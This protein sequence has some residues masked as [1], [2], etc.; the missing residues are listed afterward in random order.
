MG[1]VK[2]TVIGLL[3]VSTG[4]IYVSERV[5]NLKEIM[6]KLIPVPSNFRNLS[7]KHWILYFNFDLTLHNPTTED[8][9]PN[10]IIV[11]VKRVEVKT[12]DGKLI[13][14]VNVNKTS[15]NVPAKGKYMLKD[16]AVEVDIY[17]NAMNALSLAKI[18]GIED[19]KVDIVCGILGTEYVIPQL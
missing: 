3:A 19:I 6:V 9:N 16:L 13:A 1:L 12:A 4:C 10:G 14:K 17:S 18:K 7:I 2:Y 11:T 8:F 5:K 15:I